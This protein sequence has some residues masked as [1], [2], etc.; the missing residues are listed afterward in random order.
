[1]E[2]RSLEQYITNNLEI[3]GKYLASTKTAVYIKDMDDWK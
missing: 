1:M 3:I 2:G